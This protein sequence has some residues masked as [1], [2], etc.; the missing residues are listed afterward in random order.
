ML[1]CTHTQLAIFIH[2]FSELCVSAVCSLLV[3]HP[4]RPRL[5]YK[6]SSLET[7]HKQPCYNSSL[8]KS[9]AKAAEGYMLKKGLKVTA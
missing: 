6:C 4:F 7:A 9:L 1:C 8:S 3:K 5:C 2:G